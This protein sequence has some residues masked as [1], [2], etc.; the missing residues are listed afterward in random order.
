MGFLLLF[1]LTNE[2]SFINVRNWLTQL[3]ANSY[4]DT[5][6]IVLC[7]NKSDLKDA[8]TI[9]TERAMELAKSLGWVAIVSSVSILWFIK[10]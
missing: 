9:T 1:D 5:P 2:Q 7:G 6:D 3:Q 8:R 4:C 10:I